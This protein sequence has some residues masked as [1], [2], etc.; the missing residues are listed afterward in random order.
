M[1]N[2][3]QKN[4]NR[5]KNKNRNKQ[6]QQQQQQNSKNSSGSSKIAEDTPEHNSYTVES[7][8][9]VATLEEN[10]N[11]VGDD[12]KEIEISE[13]VPSPPCDVLNVIKCGTV[14]NEPATTSNQ[15]PTPACN[16]ESDKNM[17]NEKSKLS[18]NPGEVSASC[19]ANPEVPLTPT[20]S[21][22]P[23]AKV[24]VHRI[25]CEEPP[26]RDIK[27]D[28]S[29]ETSR[30]CAS[31]NEKENIPSEQ[32]KT[33]VKRNIEESKTEEIPEK[34]VKVIVHKIHLENSDRDKGNELKAL[35]PVRIEEVGDESLTDIEEL[36]SPIVSEVDS[37]AEWEDGDFEQSSENE[38]TMSTSMTSSSISQ[39]EKRKQKR[40]A[41]ENHFLPQMLSPRF[42]DSISEENSDLS[43]CGDNPLSRSASAENATN[44]NEQK[45][46]KLNAKFPKSSLDFSKTHKPT[47]TLNTQST[48]NAIREEPLAFAVEARFHET[49]AAD[50]SCTT[51]KSFLSPEA[52]LAEMVFINSASSSMS[53]LNEVDH[54]DRVSLHSAS[55]I[56]FDLDTDAK[57]LINKPGTENR[58]L[59]SSSSAAE[60]LPINTNKGS[61]FV[62]NNSRISSSSSSPAIH[63]LVSSNNEEEQEP[64]SSPMLFS[65]G[66]GPQRF[67]DAAQRLLSD[68]VARSLETSCDSVNTSSVSSLRAD[69]NAKPPPEVP[70]ENVQNMNTVRDI[71]NTDTTQT[72]NTNGNNIAICGDVARTLSNQGT[73]QSLRGSPPPPPIPPPPQSLDDDQKSLPLLVQNVEQHNGQLHN[74]EKLSSIPSLLSNTNATDLSISPLSSLTRQESLESHCSDSTTFSQCTAINVGPTLNKAFDQM[75]SISD[76]KISSATSSDIGQQNRDELNASP[77]DPKKLRL[78]CAE[79]LAGLPYGGEVLEELATLAQ[80]IG[81]VRAVNVV[82]SHTATTSTTTT[83]GEGK[84]PYPLPELP[85][86]DDLRLSLNKTENDVPQRPHS[87]NHPESWLGVPTSFDPKVLVCLSPSQRTYI[88][89]QQQSVTASTTTKEDQAKPDDLLDAHQKFVERRGYHEFSKEQLATLEQEKLAEQQL[90]QTAAMMKKLRKS[91]TPPPPQIPPPP[92]PTKSSETAT[93]A[94]NL[95]KRSI[96]S[97][98]SISTST[99]TIKSSGDVTS[100]NEADKTTTAR[101]DGEENKHRLLSIIQDTSDS[102][103]ILSRQQQTVAETSTSSFENNSRQ[104]TNTY[105]HQQQQQQQ[106]QP[107]QE[108]PATPQQAKP[109]TFIVPIT[110]TNGSSDKTYNSPPS[111][112]GNMQSVESSLGE[113]FPTLGSANIFDKEQKRFSNI[114]S[115]SSQHQSLADAKPK[116]YSSIE[117]HSYESQKRIENGQVVH[118]YSNSK[119]DKQNI[120]DAPPE[121]GNDDKFSS[122][123]LFSSGI[124]SFSNIPNPFEP[125]QQSILTADKAKPDDQEIMSAL[126]LNNQSSATL[127]SSFTSAT[128]STSNMTTENSHRNLRDEVD[129]VK[130]NQSEEHQKQNASERMTALRRG[131]EDTYEEFR[132]RAKE[133]AAASATAATDARVL[134]T[135][136]VTSSGDRT[137]GNSIISSSSST[138]TTAANKKTVF[139]HDH[140]KLFKEFDDLSKQLNQE[141]ET[142]K[143][144]REQ[145]EKSASLYDLNRIQLRQKQQIEEFNKQRHEHMNELEKEIERSMKSRQL[146]MSSMER[147]LSSGNGSNGHTYQI[148][149]QIENGHT[150]QTSPGNTEGAPPIPEPPRTYQIPIQIDN[151][152]T[153][154]VDSRFR[155]AESMFNLNDEGRNARTYSSSQCQTDD[156]WSKYASDLGSSE[157]IARPF[158]REVEICYQRRPGGIR[159]PRLTASTNDLSYNSHTFDQ[160]NAY[161]V[162]R[163]H[164]QAPMLNKAPQQNRPHYGSCYSMIE[165]DPNPKY[166]STT[167]R[168]GVSPAPQTSGFHPIEA[169]V[170]EEQMRQRRAS[171]PRELHEQQLKY[172]ACKEEE[173]RTE[174]E[175]LQKERLRLMEEVNKAQSMPMPQPSAR[176]ESYRCV[177]KLPTLT[178]DEVFRQQMAEEWL[179]KVA[180]REKRRLQNIIKISKVHEEESSEHKTMQKNLGDEFLNRVMERRSKL[181]MPADSDWE[182]GAE[183]QPA[184]QAQ[185]SETEDVPPVKILEGEHEANLRSLPRH[186][187]EFAKFSNHQRDEIEGGHR[188][189]HQEEERSQETTDNSFSKAF[190]KSTMVKTVKTV[191]APMLPENGGHGESMHTNETNV[192]NASTANSCNTKANNNNNTCNI[193]TQT[194]SLFS[195]GVGSVLGTAVVIGLSAWTAWR[196]FT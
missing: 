39:R 116:R 120:G 33:S 100:V 73:S 139:Q 108:H 80:N 164:H 183:S 166:I 31:S 162:R 13:D 155:R 194:D 23:Q 88:E 141:L 12:R 160:Y 99:G 170:S 106:Q 61:E 74:E 130:Q 34:Q 82:K 168:R 165:R 163:S 152:S 137:N 142:S 44:T 151:S 98:S 2:Y 112:S 70:T 72:A 187:R 16:I 104:S 123:T 124:P 189:Q 122:K 78:L 193:D 192:H 196:R 134:P 180:E 52:E 58:E 67:T 118:D 128:N 25:V 145:K 157:N 19:T 178:E 24:I 175:R 54:M 21:S 176:R 169:T 97:T 14:S 103:S 186:L 195:L 56:T 27:I 15:S 81:E 159:A 113:M 1:P 93:K 140:E 121:V 89:Q 66:S 144:Q 188:E 43:E 10:V 135:A 156:D 119:H 42:L 65:Y 9:P 83:E 85:H 149:I 115:S 68:T 50:E 79:T 51:L 167:S 125:S 38:M 190:K 26:N 29:K 86:I 18:E 3:R 45:S 87:P 132:Q 101:C 129:F 47:L 150:V 105:H 57:D 136:Q 126:K 172:I 77:T 40:I 181:S 84:M 20:L 102:Q 49:P 36:K 146:R 41:L 37:A 173:L 148:P 95:S 32:V 90:L 11:L 76:P 147:S 158:A 71:I 46:Q 53:D 117:T 153:T 22:R 62:N 109:S 107:K 96:P 4:R 138:T 55:S 69:K 35:S 60:L 6:Q 63:Q 133:A 143:S 30:D 5:N 92:V 184:N 185:T 171:L 91:L 127:N 59:T 94:Q 17:G 179:N 7:P 48:R 182:S 64:Q 110:L 177:P 28:D 114:E 8:P 191:R 75:S 154:S 131:I 161:N 111:S 174:F